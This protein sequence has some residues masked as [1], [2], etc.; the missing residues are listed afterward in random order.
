M[1]QKAAILLF[2]M[3]LCVHLNAQQMQPGTDFAR[4]YVYVKIDAVVR[5][6]RQV[7]CDGALVAEVKRGKFFV[8]NLASGKHTLS[9]TDGIPVSLDVR[10]GKDYFVRLERS[11][12]VSPSSKSPFLC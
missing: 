8:L 5:S 2:L 3:V 10:S 6:W 11:F 12:I 9:D 1:K 7:L 4:V